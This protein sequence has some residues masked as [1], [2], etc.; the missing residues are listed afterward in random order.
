MDAATTLLATAA[1]FTVTL[2]YAAM[3]ELVSQRAGAVNVSVEG[4][5]LG[6]AFLATV[7]AQRSN[8][9]VGVLGGVAAGLVVAAAQ[10]LLSHYWKADQ[11]VIGL[12][13][14]ILV[15][16]LTS[17]LQEKVTIRP[18]TPG[19]WKLPLLHEVPV[20]GDSLFSRSWLSYLLLPVV[21]IVWF[22]LYR[23]RWGLQIRSVGDD[24][25]SAELAGVPVGRRRRQAV[26]VA[27]LGAGL[28]GAHLALADVGTFTQN[29]T[30]G[31]GFIVIAAVLFGSWRVSGVVYG[32]ALFGT[33]ESLRLA[34]PAF[35]VSLTPELLIVA[36]Y[37]LALAT[38]L[39]LRRRSRQPGCLGRPFFALAPS[40]R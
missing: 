8:V 17:F 19:R 3:G 13:L 32:C 38:L 25:E 40:A 20:L 22:S 15:L 4:M 16:G 29:M 6:S 36:P 21:P 34:L 30:A 24:A 39:T 5:M 11:F 23:T 9:M 26:L 1:I 18:K 12:S 10:A 31:T 35:G 28:A 27:G 33:T 14:N 7:V 2:L 37:L